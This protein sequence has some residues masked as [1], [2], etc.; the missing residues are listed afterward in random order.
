MYEDDVTAQIQARHSWERARQAAFWESLIG[1]LPDRSSDLLSFEEV[2]NQLR[3]TQKTYRGLQEISLSHIRGSVGRYR[4]FTLSFLPRNSEMQERWER[5][6]K[7]ASTQGVP[8]IE[9]YQVGEA[10]FVLDGNHRVSVARQMGSNLIE[11]HVWEFA[12][13]VGLSGEADLNELLIKTE[14]AQFLEKT[15]LDR[16]HPE[17][18]INFTAPG[19][20][21]ELEWQI[22][23]YRRAL[24]KIDQERVLYEQA[25]EAWYDMIYTPALQI[26]Q[27]QGVLEQFPDRTEA[28]LFVWVWGHSQELLQREGSAHLAQVAG[29]LRQGRRWGILRT[30]WRMVSGLFR[31]RVSSPDK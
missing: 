17:A 14:Y 1:L 7:I 19:H 22:E 21:R 25:V 20:Y 4:D 2:K 18:Q 16:S 26:I 5:I 28:D 11:A 24:E 15:Q 8:P 13:P 27:D 23:L 9:V 6:N 30:I 12:T 10:Y 3:L 31:A 29:Q